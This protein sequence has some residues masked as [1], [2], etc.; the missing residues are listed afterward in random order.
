M[1]SLELSIIMPCLNEAETL[2]TCIKKAQWYL[3]EYH[4]KGEVVIAD[5]GSIDSSPEIATK[6][7]ATL[8][9]V[10]EKGYGSALMGGILAARGEFIIMADADDSY[11]FTKLNP[12]VEKLREGYDLVMGNRFKGGIKPNAMPFLHK[13]LGNPVLTWL[14]KLFFHSPCSDFHCGLRGFRKQA[15]LSLN[16]RTTGMEF[17][18]EMVVKSTLNGLKITEVPTTLSPDGR[19]RKPHLRTWRDGWRHLRFLLLYSPRW[20]FLYPGFFLMIMGLISTVIL[21][22][23]PRVHSLLYSST[24]I[25]IGFQL[26]N[27][28]IFTKVYAIQEGLLPQDKKL[29]KFIDF[30]TLEQGLIFGTILF[31]LGGITSIFALF[32]WKATDF[33]AL[34][35]VLTMRLVIPSVTAIALGL[36]I[37]FASFFLSIF[38]LKTK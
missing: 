1:D 28:A 31:L 9:N 17:A 32:Q 37:I 38:Q 34:N 26:V 36:Q 8:I 13:Y 23:S 6:M 16:L 30:F 35:P 24:A 10:K 3:Q 21:L 18:S 29:L 27:F 5:N 2:A 4:I 33:T 12:F 25:I 20:L 14:G 15:I 11:D 7:G 19:S 22:Y